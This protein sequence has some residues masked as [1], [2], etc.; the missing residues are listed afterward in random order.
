M[1][2][3]KKYCG[4]DE[5]GRGALAGPVVVASVIFKSY[6]NIPFGIQDSKLLTFL[7]RKKLYLKI[8]KTADIG[9]G[10]IS[11]RVIDEIGINKS[12]NNASEKSINSNSASAELIFLDA[13]IKPNTKIKFLNIIKGD[14]NYVSIAAASI[15]A[16]YHRDN[17]MIKLS[18][19]YKKYNWK[20][21]K[22]Y[23]T[24][25]HLLAIENYGITK[26]H[27]KSYKPMCKVND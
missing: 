26:E 1:K 10:V 3:K 5:A 16:K 13:G 23:G 14:S 24:K 15:V 17:I 7:Q 11:S 22:G 4:I 18:R 9:L 6:E 8:K 19:E 20:Q 12:I 2:I 27:R 21:N 25:D